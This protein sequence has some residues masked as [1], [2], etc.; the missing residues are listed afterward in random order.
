MMKEMLEGLSA[1]YAFSTEDLEIIKNFAVE[2]AM[3]AMHDSKYGNEA[4]ELSALVHS[5]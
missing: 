1:K 3:A 2:Y 5:E 4:F